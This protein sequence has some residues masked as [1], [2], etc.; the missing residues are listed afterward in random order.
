MRGVRGV[1]LREH[2][3]NAGLWEGDLLNPKPLQK[4]TCEKHYTFHLQSCPLLFLAWLD[5]LS[6][7]EAVPHISHSSHASPW[8]LTGVQV[9]E[10]RE[11][12]MVRDG[13]TLLLFFIPTAGC[14]HTSW[15]VK[16]ILCSVTA[17]HEWRVK[18]KSF[19]GKKWVLRCKGLKV[20]EKELTFRDPPDQK[21]MSGQEVPDLEGSCQGQGSSLGQPWKKEAQQWSAPSARTDP[22]SPE[23]S[24][25]TDWDPHL[26]WW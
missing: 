14:L 1:C 3:R 9:W 17:H 4:P 16:Q 19:Q 20:E 10:G 12:S 21:A 7:S 15:D 26:G 23:G 22:I 13:V 2:L 6:D 25:V 5:T 11:G 18:S 24:A 8:L